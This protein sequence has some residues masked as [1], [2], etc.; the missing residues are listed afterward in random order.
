[1]FRHIFR[2]RLKK[3]VKTKEMIFWTL[4]FPIILSIFFSMA[5][6]NLDSSEGFDPINTAVVLNEDYRNTEF[7]E[8]ILADV[9]VGED[10]LMN[11]QETS[12]E[13]AEKLLEDGTISGYI[14]ADEMLELH[15]K[16]SGLSQNIL[17][18]FL[19]NLNQTFAVIEDVA[20]T[21]PAQIE[22]LIAAISDPRVYTEEMEKETAPPSQMLNYFYSLIAMTCMYGAFFGADEVTEIQA[23]ISDLAARLNIAPVHKMKAFLASS[24]A[25]YLV[26]MINVS[27]LLT[28][29]RFALGIEFGERIGLLILTTFVATATGISFGAFISALIRKGFN[30]KVALIVSV[31]MVGSFLSGMMYAQMKYIIH[32]NLPI[33][34]YV[35][36][37][38][39]ITDSF[40]SL[41]YFDT[42][43]R[44]FTNIV[45]LMIMTFIFSTATYMVLRRRKYA[46]L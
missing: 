20:S 6:Q 45:I 24:A 23:N 19:D 22:P 12:Q 8:E 31:T 26:L 44:W 28:F 29:L 40:Y 27:I 42:L 36:P 1:M 39:L 10:R 25:S 15:V 17:R 11:L 4:A 5:F 18:L 13:E 43:E 34:S 33:L 7:F 38:S 3:L 21:D 2:Y 14:T 35:N 37:V 9:S 41:Y 46:S 32:N 16:S 30:L